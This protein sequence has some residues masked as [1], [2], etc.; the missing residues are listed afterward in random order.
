VFE[1]GTHVWR[2]FD[3]WPPVAAKPRTLYFREGGRLSWEAPIE[4]Q[5]RA[6]TY[7]SDPNRPVPFVGYT[8]IAM[9]AEHMVAD[10]RFAATR[11]DVLVYQSEVLEED[12]TVAGPVSPR[13]FVSTTGTDSDWVVKLI[14]VYPAD[15]EDKGRP[16]PD[17]EGASDVPPPRVKMAGYQQL[18]RGNP[19]RGRFR[20]SFEAPDA[21]VPGRVEEIRFDMPDV[22]H[23]FRRGHRIMVQVQSSWFPLFDRNPQTFVP[24]RSARP[25]DFKVATQQVFR[26]RDQ[27]SG[28]VVRVL[29]PTSGF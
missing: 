13:V 1:T 7:V 2:Q 28:V 20:H 3:A 14:D 15:L 6:D 5:A 24:I 10:Q 22:L 11:P 16:G 25:E 4:A 18:L 8:T 17:A 23:T 21:M 26:W 12:V 29:P 9:P 27:P 19:L